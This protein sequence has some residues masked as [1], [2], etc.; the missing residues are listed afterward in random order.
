MDRSKLLKMLATLSAN[1][2]IAGSLTRLI[3]GD[4]MSLSEYAQRNP[5]VSQSGENNSSGSDTLPETDASG[6][7]GEN[8]SASSAGNGSPGTLGNP[9]DGDL[10]GRPAGSGSPDGENLMTENLQNETSLL[11]GASLNGT[12]QLEQRV[13]LTD[14][15]YYEPLSDH[16][17][18]YITGV[19]Y[20]A[21]NTEEEAA[22][23]A[24]SYDD[25]R[26][27][28]V[29]HYDFDGNPAEGELICNEYIAQDLVEIFY[30]LYYNEYQIERMV[31]IDEYDGDDT[32]S[33]EDNN[34]SCFNYRVVEGS[35]SLSKHAYGLAIDINPFYNP[36]VTYERDGTEKVSPAAALGY[37]D[38]SVNFPYKIDE[39]DLCCRLFKEHGFIWGGN[40]NSLKDYQHF[41][42]TP[43]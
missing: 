17:R 43:K 9:A 19:S 29:L 28:H 11:T 41:Q 22:L 8:P 26:Y 37:A 14:D 10:S 33:M 16:L 31:L 13:T 32:A 23:P 7:S 25:L 34:T 38:R 39:E 30:E 21:V 6:M 3:R 36:Y 24:V 27:V 12:S 5:P 18:R 4:S 42:K 1:V 2:V 40:W 15:F 20:P 35:E